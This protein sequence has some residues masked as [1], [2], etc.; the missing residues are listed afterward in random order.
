MEPGSVIIGLAIV[1]AIVVVAIGVI[2]LMLARQGRGAAERAKVVVAP[3]TRIRERGLTTVRA[4]RDQGEGIVRRGKALGHDLSRK[5]RAARH[6]VEE[7]AH[8]GR[9]PVE[10]VTEPIAR[11][12]R[13]ME[14]ISKLHAAARKAAGS[15]Q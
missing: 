2:G 3:V 7:V 4:T 8:P 12:Q 6:L 9:P 13:L 14:R 10:P 15:R 1:Q 11:G 5:W